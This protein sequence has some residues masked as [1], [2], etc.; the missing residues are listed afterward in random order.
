MSSDENEK[1]AIELLRQK[2]LLLHRNNEMRLPQKN[3]FTDAE[4]CLIKQKLGAWPRALEKA[5]MKSES[6]HTR[7]KRTVEKRIKARNRAK[8]AEKSL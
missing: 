7:H 8:D 4:V 2:S 6:D 1:I 3:D 5:G